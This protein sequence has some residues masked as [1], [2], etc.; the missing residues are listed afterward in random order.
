RKI[1]RRALR[2]ARLLGGDL[3]ML[4]NMARSVEDLMADAYPELKENG[5]RI[6]NVIRAEE[7]RF[8]HTIDIGLKRLEIDLLPQM[9]ARSRLNRGKS[10]VLA[11]LQEVKQQV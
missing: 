10:E 4:T 6:E 7:D 8:A 5:R 1:M 2:H 3:Y 9:E 11:H